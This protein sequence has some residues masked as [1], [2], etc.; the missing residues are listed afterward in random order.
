LSFEVNARER[1]FRRRFDH[2]VRVA[3]GVGLVAEKDD[4]E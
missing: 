1:G 2:P 3:F 4:S